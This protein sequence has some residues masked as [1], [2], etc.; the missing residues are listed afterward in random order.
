ME[1]EDLDYKAARK[2]LMDY[3]RQY[4]VESFTLEELEKLF[5]MVDAYGNKDP[6]FTKTNIETQILAASSCI[7]QEC[8]YRHMPDTDLPQLL[9]NL[10]SI[11][12][13]YF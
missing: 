9:F 7:K 10:R 4:P 1:Y 5:A 11:G 2:N 3:V 6:R 8:A 13:Q 12:F